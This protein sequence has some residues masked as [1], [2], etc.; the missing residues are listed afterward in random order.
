LDEI[1]S[2]DLNAQATFLQIL[3][4]QQ[5]ERVGGT[6]TIKIDVRIIAASNQ[7]S[8]SAGETRQVSRRPILQAQC[9]SDNDAGPA[10]PPGRYYSLV[11][12]LLQRLQP[13]KKW[14]LT[15]EAATL[16]KNY[17][18]PGNIR[19]LETCLNRL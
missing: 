4:E 9:S 1:S 13:E 19:E 2:L 3:Q 18:W 15:P 11:H 16:L 7:D 6:Q 10:G 8:Q 12:F 14:M 5:F 17:P